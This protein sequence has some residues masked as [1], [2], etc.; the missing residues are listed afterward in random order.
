MKPNMPIG[1]AATWLAAG[2]LFGVG[3]AIGSGFVEDARS[4][5]KHAKRADRQQEI[6]GSGDIRAQRERE[7]NGSQ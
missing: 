7:R 2:A 1:H 4:R 3:F 5:R 6:I